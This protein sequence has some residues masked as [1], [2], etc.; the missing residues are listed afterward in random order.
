MTGNSHNLSVRMNYGFSGIL[1]DAEEAQPHMLFR[2][3]LEYV[4]VRIGTNCAEKGSE[5]RLYL[6][7]QEILA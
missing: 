1:L 6:T 3:A 5:Q 7:Y 2:T 4:F